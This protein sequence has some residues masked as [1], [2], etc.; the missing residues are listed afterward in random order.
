MDNFE[1][2]IR[3]NRE[4]LDRY[5]PPSSVWNKI[6]RNIRLE[7]SPVYK[8][9][10]IAAMV[11]FIIGSSVFF[12]KSGYLSKSNGSID[13]RSNQ[14]NNQL[15]ETEIYYNNLINSLYRE[16]TP[17][18]TGNPEI[19]KEFVTDISHLDSICV[20]IKNDLKDNISNQEVVEA[21]IQNYRIKIYLLEDMLTILKEDE[22]NT[23]K[24]NNYEL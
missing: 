5:N 22:T 2:Y 12:F 7:K 1:E 13:L 19:K 3:Q 14:N 6:L 17:F 24:N 16:A 20:E 11:T 10:S 9:L 8:W 21:L 18:L 15:E 4:S 23:D